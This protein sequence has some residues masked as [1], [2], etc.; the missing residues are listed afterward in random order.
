MSRTQSWKRPSSSVVLGSAIAT[1]VLT[2]SAPAV[3]GQSDQDQTIPTGW[4]WLYNVTAAQVDERINA[5]FRITDLE[6]ANPDPLRFNAVF[7]ENSG[8]YAKGWWWYYG[9]DAAFVSNAINAL[10]ARLIDLESYEVGGIQR[11]AVVMIH[12]SGEDAAGWWWYYNVSTAFLDAF[13]AANNARIIDLDTYVLGGTRYYNAVMVQNVG[14]QAQGWWWYFN[15][16]ADF[17]NT[18]LGENNARLTDLEPHI[19]DATPTYDCIM[20][21]SQGE[22]WWWYYGANDTF[23]GEAINQN[24][25]RLIDLERYSTPTGTRFAVVM[26]NNSNALTTR[27]GDILRDGTDGFSGCYLKQVDGPVLA[28]LNADTV[29][30]PASMI[31]VLHHTHAMTQ[32]RDDEIELT[33]LIPTFGGVSTSCPV[34]TGQFMIEL[35]DCLQQMMEQSHN[36]RTQA[37]RTYFGEDNINATAQSLGMTNTLLQHRI[38]CATGADGAHEQPNQLTLVDAGKLYEAVADGLLSFDLFGIHFD[39]RDTFYELMS[40]GLFGGVS[41]I[42]TQE[43][44]RL[45]I[46]AA[47]REAFR[48]LVYQA[49]KGG[50]YGLCFPD[51]IYHQT[52]GGWIRMPFKSGCGE[53]FMEEYVHGTFVNNATDN[54]MA[55]NAASTAMDEILRDEIRAALDSWTNCNFDDLHDGDVDHVDHR[56]FLSCMTDPDAPLRRDC[57]NFDSDRDEDVDFRDWRAFQNAFSFPRR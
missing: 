9:V 20:V 10:G 26:V 39:L 47:P 27:I 43:A 34:D 1:L 52:R 33:D 37:I 49:G 6:I 25:A 38:G 42:I 45:G 5:G 7:G 23:V 35:Q 17:I 8:A 54:D 11:F 51:C 46:D 3:R 18:K 44:N 16:S 56:A 41:D 36:P 13:I 19:I 29:F 50:S 24:G 14:A 53:L 48:A 30:E 28:Y 22:H 15:V 55:S 4:W 32:V 12:N 57:E 21:S 31:K 2:W 40:D